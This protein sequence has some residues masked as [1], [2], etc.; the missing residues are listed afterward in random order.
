MKSS[1]LI[2]IAVWRGCFRTAETGQLGPLFYGGYTVDCTFAVRYLLSE[3]YEI[4]T[5]F[6]GVDVE[7]FGFGREE[8]N[9]LP[10]VFRINFPSICS[11]A[12]I[13]ESAHS[14]NRFISQTVRFRHS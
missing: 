6:F 5:P 9:I 7:L 3:A 8:F 2:E 4:A 13:K 10:Q 12:F 14:L 1:T 11:P